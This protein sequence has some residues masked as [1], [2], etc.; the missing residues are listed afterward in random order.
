MA[1]AGV[2][3]SS[4]APSTVP[5]SPDSA[6]HLLFLLFQN[7][8]SLCLTAFQIRGP[9]LCCGC[10]NLRFVN[11]LNTL[12]FSHP[13]DFLREETGESRIHGEDK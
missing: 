4:A 7:R 3:F 8:K 2:G 13:A 9:G 12:Y 1:S 10:I 6:S 5:W 11:L